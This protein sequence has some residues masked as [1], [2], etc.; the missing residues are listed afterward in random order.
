[1]HNT[2]YNTI[3]NIMH[4]THYNTIE[5]LYIFYITH[6]HTITENYK[7]GT[8]VFIYL[9]KVPEKLKKWSL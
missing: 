7:E 5:Y 2:H 3:H 9:K 8:Q 4:N 6:C 1:M